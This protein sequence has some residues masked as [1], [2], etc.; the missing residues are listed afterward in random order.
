MNP[1]SQ[2]E[3]SKLL[4]FHAENVLKGS[5]INYFLASQAGNPFK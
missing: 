2:D 5:C 4:Y 1:T 3:Q